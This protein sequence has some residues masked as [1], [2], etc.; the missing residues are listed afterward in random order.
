MGF[1]M[2]AQAIKFIWDAMSIFTQNSKNCFDMLFGG[3]FYAAASLSISSR[4]KRMD[5]LEICNNA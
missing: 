5:F 1:A 4:L 3:A 2:F